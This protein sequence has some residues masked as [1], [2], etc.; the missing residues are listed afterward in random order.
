MKKKY[1]CKVALAILMMSCMFGSI[2]VHAGTVVYEPDNYSMSQMPPG[3]YLSTYGYYMPG[4]TF[5]NH[6]NTDFQDIKISSYSG[7]R[8]F[9]PTF[10]GNFDF[11]DSVYN[12]IFRVTFDTVTSMASLQ[13][14]GGKLTPSGGT[15]NAYSETGTLL[16]S[17]SISGTVADGDPKQT[18][19]VSASGIKYV[20]LVPTLGGGLRT[21]YLSF[22]GSPT[23]RSTM[24]F[25]GY[26]DT[27]DSGTVASL[28][29]GTATGTRNITTSFTLAGEVD[30]GISTLAGDVLSFTGTDTD[31]FVLAMQYT[32]QAVADAGLTESD[33][34]LLWADGS[35]DFVNAVLGNSNAETTGE[36]LFVDGAYNSSVHTLGYYGVDTENN[37]VWAVLDH[38]S[39]YAPG[40]VPEP[41]TICLVLAG[42]VGLKVTRKF[43]AKV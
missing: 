9:S 43:Y 6:R 2:A 22:Y 40:V 13:V 7:D 26:S 42:I 31:M 11:S 3:A 24:A 39:D 17:T 21:D 27:S 18:L 29:G 16:G 37:T 41:S 32:D 35:G 28:I 4:V 14:W 15:L 30:A 33:L 5:N 20:E 36:D 1:S 25:T 23:Y 38:N 34:R 8:Y 10:S 12:N 19:S